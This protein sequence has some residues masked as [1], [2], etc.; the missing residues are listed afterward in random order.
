MCI[1]NPLK[2]LYLNVTQILM[3]GHNTLEFHKMSDCQP[4]DEN[5]D[6]IIEEEFGINLKIIKGKYLVKYSKHLYLYLIFL[7]KSHDIPDEMTADNPYV[8][9]NII[10]F[11]NNWAK[12]IN[13]VKKIAFYYKDMANIYKYILLNSTDGFNKKNGHL[14]EKIKIMIDSQIAN[15]P[16][17]LNYRFIYQ[18]M[19]DILKKV[20]KS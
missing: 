17:E 4:L 9:K 5:S 13:R 7:N 18:K 20:K 16:V 3:R 14:N 1:E 15:I 19:N 12:K 8:Y 6:Y 2:H 10:S 11:Y